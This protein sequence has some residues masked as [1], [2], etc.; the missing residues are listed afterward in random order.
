[1]EQTYELFKRKIN[2]WKNLR[3]KYVNLEMTIHQ[4]D[5]FNQDVYLMPRQFPISRHQK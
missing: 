4:S 1:M 2:R 5:D 3:N